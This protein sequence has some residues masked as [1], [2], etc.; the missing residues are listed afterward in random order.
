MPKLTLAIHTHILLGFSF[1][2]FVSNTVALFQIQLCCVVSNTALLH[3]IKY[4]CIVLYNVMCCITSNS[5]VLYQEQFYCKKYNCIVLYQMQLYCPLVTQSKT[6]T[7]NRTA[8]LLLMM[9]KLL[10]G[11]PC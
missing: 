9:I 10:A 1:F 3:C 8:M 11:Y 7:G 5:V 4:G 6:L 2:M